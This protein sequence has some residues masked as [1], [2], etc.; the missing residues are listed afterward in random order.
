MQPLHAE[1]H[2]H[3]SFLRNYATTRECFYRPFGT[4]FLFLGLTSD[5]SPGLRSVARWGWFSYFTLA[6]NPNQIFCFFHLPC[7]NR[8]ALAMAMELSAMAMEAKT[9]LDFMCRGIASQ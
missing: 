4:W 3:H 7:L 6:L 2:T 8:I 9:P 5:L 1:R